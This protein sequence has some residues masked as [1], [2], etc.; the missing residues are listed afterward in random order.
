MK[1]F[2]RKSINVFI[3]F[4]CIFSS[5][6]FVS[7][8][9]N[10]SETNPEKP[11]TNQTTPE[12]VTVEVS[13]Y[14]D[15]KN[16]AK[17]TADIIKLTKDI[18]IRSNTM[19]PKDFFVFERK[20]TLDLNGYKI[21]STND[22]F[23]D[24]SCNRGMLEIS[25]D[26][27]VTITGNGKIISNE[28]DAYAIQVTNGGKITI[29]NGE[30]IGNR[31]CVSV[32][33]GSAEIRGGTFSI[34]QKELYQTYDPGSGLQGFGYVI[35]CYNQHIAHCSIIIKGG[36]FVNFN[37]KNNISNGENTNYLDTG[38]TSTLLPETGDNLKIYR[39]S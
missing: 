10:N 35:D 27:D 21:Y 26:A 34:K 32:Y 17:G 9:K 3:V 22:I 13:S 18:D 20:V 6:I 31:S 38:Y 8:G 29:L 16:A 5:C 25:K 30:F 11:Q 15:L 2:F 39:V 33:Y 24:A 23:D 19:H 37:P 1:Y 7:C 12:L 4:I 36:D 28:N 14:Y